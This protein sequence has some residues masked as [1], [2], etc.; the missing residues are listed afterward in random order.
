MN[1]SD[2]EIIE[3]ALAAQ[4]A[5]RK[6]VTTAVTTV[7]PTSGVLPIQNLKSLDN[8]RAF[9]HQVVPVIV[10]VLVSIDVVTN[11]VA[12]AWIPF[13]FA[14]A[15]NVLSVGNTVDNLRKALY[16]AFGALQAGGLVTI[17]L[18]NWHPEYIPIASA[19]IALIAGF[20]NRFYTPTTTMV[21]VAVK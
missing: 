17:L 15:D 2:Q 3:K 21:P 1:E 14:I 18:T 4:R 20:M 16:A 9:I 6:K 7:M 10:T 5:R 11:D 19:G 13:V 8:W 12:M